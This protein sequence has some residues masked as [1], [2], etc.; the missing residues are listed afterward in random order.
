MNIVVEMT[1][2]A[3][4]TI[5]TA[6]TKPT[7][8]INMLKE[9]KTRH[10]LQCSH[11]TDQIRTVELT[12]LGTSREELSMIPQNS[13]SFKIAN[14]E[15]KT[16]SYDIHRHTIVNSYPSGVPCHSMMEQD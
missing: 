8:T 6:T 9:G 7:T 14:G 1:M 16:S 11:S 10:M 12:L 15:K 3:S 13:K 2:T 4:V 5:M